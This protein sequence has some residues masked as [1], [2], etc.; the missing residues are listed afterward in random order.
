MVEGIDDI[1]KCAP[2]K[3]LN[4]FSQYPTT[5]GDSVYTRWTV[6]ESLPSLTTRVNSP[7]VVQASVTKTN[8]PSQHQDA[9]L[10][11]DGEPPSSRTKND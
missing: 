7:S 8:E 5:R 6:P 3:I 4:S 2:L 11:A 10:N 9:R 1:G